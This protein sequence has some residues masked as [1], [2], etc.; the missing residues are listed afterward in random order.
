MSR[1]KL[2]EHFIRTD[3]NGLATKIKNLKKKN[4]KKTK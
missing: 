2:Y 4:I 1:K 3:W